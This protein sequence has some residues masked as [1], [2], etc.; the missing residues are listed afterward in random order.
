M[1]DKKA[2]TGKFVRP[3][4]SGW[5]TKKAETDEFVRPEQQGWRTKK[6]KQVDSSAAM[7]AKHPA[8]LNGAKRNK[9]I[10]YH[11]DIFHNF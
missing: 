4:Q 5:R 10:P 8:Q 6:P 11:I 3:E 9:I 7:G 1:A 2:D